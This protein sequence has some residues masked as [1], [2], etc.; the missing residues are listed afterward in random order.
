MRAGGLAAALLAAGA[1]LAGAPLRDAATEALLLALPRPA[2]AEGPVV[3]AVAVTESDLAAFGPWPWERARFAAIVERLGAAGV[4]ALALDIGFPDAAP[5][6][7][8]LGAALAA[9]PAVVGRL[10]GEAPP[11][12]GFGVA[13]LGRPVLAGLPTL[14]GVEPAAVAGGAPALAA[15]PGAPV[16]AVPMLVRV[17][18]E[19]ALPGLALG[20]VAKAVGAT[21]LVVQGGPPARIQ[22]GGFALP[23]PEDG[24]LRL[25]PGPLPPPVLTVAEAMAEGPL[26]AALR[27]R[28][29]LLGA[30]APEAAPLRPSVLGPFTPSL[31]LQAEAVA[32]LA[33]G[34]VPL[35]PP[36]G[37]WAEAAAALALG[38]LAALAVR[39]RV[40]LGLGLAAGLALLWPLAAAAALALEPVLLDPALPAL[41]ALTGGAAEALAAAFRLARERRALLARFAHRLPRGTLDRLLA[42]PAAE[43]LRPERIEVAVIMTDLAGFSALTTRSEPAVLVGLL[44]D[45]LAVIERAVTAEGGTLERLTGDGVL[46]VFGAPLPQPDHRARALAAARALDAACEAFRRRPEAAALGWGETRLGI[47]AGEVMAGEVGGSR[48]T[49]TVYGDVVNLAARLQELGKTVGR[50][51]L[52][53]GIEDPSLP[54]PLGEYELRGRPGAVPVR[55]LDA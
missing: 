4:A 27:G 47:T 54:P 23:L 24:L 49:W 38:L 9:A 36:G 41:G 48:L 21:T 5:G 13:E 40:A 10:A 35:P 43:R 52:V 31:L 19:G 46:A 55:P 2:P 37:R 32:Q 22:L 30:T 20:A 7:A 1:L 18:A 14:P 15:L 39:R 50:R 26:L 6:D 8:R 3:V 29:V 34:W 12:P 16:R 28:I 44:N 53:A 17:G 33:E 45:Y 51:A 11:G 42:L 25:H